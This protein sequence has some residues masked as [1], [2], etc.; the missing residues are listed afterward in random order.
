MDMN[1]ELYLK[2]ENMPALTTGRVQQNEKEVWPFDLYWKDETIA[3]ND[4]LDM[5]MEYFWNPIVRQLS[6]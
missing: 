6:E 5:T 3:V 2:K 4:Y 1:W